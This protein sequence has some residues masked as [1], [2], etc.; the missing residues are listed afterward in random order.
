MEG[1]TH[2]GQ[3][4]EPVKRRHSCGVVDDHQVPFHLKQV[5]EGHGI[6]SNTTHNQVASDVGARGAQGSG[7][8]EVAV[9]EALLFLSSA[10]AG[11]R[12]G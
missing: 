7:V 4:V 3:V 8:G 5:G 11:T 10:N 9:T 6:F 2:P 1:A 12:E